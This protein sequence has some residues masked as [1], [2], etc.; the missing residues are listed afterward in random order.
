[1]P[2]TFTFPF[3]FDTIDAPTTVGSITPTGSLVKVPITLQGYAGSLTPTG[4]V[5]WARALSMS[6]GIT[7][8]GVLVPRQFVA[9]SGSIAISGTLVRSVEN[10][11]WSGVITP[12]GTLAMVRSR[13]RSFSGGITPSGTVVRVTSKSMSGSLWPGATYRPQSGFRPS[14]GL[15]SRKIQIHMLG[16]ST[17]SGTLATL[18]TRVRSLSGSLTPTGTLV[19]TPKLLRGRASI[20]I[21][22]TLKVRGRALLIASSIGPRHLIKS[23]IMER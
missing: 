19:H 12:V 1:M 5:V 8:T 18:R 23:I 16:S 15:L 14:A 2:F 21:G 22:G 10:L 3:D 17:P 4:T 7:P 13:F 6:G 9:P 11:R 20:A